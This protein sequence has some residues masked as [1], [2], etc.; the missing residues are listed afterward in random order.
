[1]LLLLAEFGPVTYPT[2]ANRDYYN[3]MIL[4]GF[5][6]YLEA[7]KLMIIII[8]SDDDYRQIRV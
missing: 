5:I 7:I 4:H 3:R 2:T 6:G 8:T 1:M